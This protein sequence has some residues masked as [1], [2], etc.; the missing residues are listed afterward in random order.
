M[1]LATVLHWLAVIAI[2]R[3]TTRLIIAH[4]ALSIDGAAT[5]SAATHIGMTLVVV[6]AAMCLCL[7]WSKGKQHRYKCE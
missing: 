6:T 3:T 7:L 1:M 5:V 2:H 4:I